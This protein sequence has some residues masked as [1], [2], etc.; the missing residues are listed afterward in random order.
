MQFT[1]HVSGP[2]RLSRLEMGRLLAR[3][4][5]ADEGHLRAVRR[6]DVPAGEPRPRDTSLDS[7]RWVRERSLEARLAAAPAAGR[8][9]SAR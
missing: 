1:L 2:E 8:Y 6:A 5:G 4:M 3:Q 9:T 7:S